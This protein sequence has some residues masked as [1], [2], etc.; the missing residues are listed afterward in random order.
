MFV[1]VAGAEPLGCVDR[2]FLC[3]LSG[4]G[5]RNLNELCAKDAVD[6]EIRHFIR[7]ESCS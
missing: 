3:S 2:L 1:C 7:N 4:S 6:G 5:L